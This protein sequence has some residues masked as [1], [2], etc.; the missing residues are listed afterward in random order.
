VSYVYQS[1]KR[2]KVKD[3]INSNRH[4]QASKQPRKRE[5]AKSKQQTENSDRETANRKESAPQA[6]PPGRF[7]F[8]E[9]I[10]MV[11]RREVVQDDDKDAPVS[12]FISRSQVLDR[13]G[14]SY[15]TVWDLM[16]H[17]KFPRSR[18]LGG[19]SMWIEREIELWILGRPVRK[20][21][22]DPRPGKA[23]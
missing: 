15:P 2:E 12:R 11:P 17:G 23:A 8:K 1:E 18:S 7:C 19:R 9:L 10:A 20:L 6:I 16:R 21:K 22:G 14:L 5:K 4:Q 13:V 3:S